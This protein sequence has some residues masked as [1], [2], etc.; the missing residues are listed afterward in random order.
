MVGLTLLLIF[1]SLLASA[2]GVIIAL[3]IQYHQ[4]EEARQER[5]GW[6]QAWEARQR[7][8]E[9]KQGKNIVD[10]EKRLSH[11]IG[12]LRADWHDWHNGWEEQ[13]DQIRLHTRVRLDMEQEIARLPHVEDVSIP[14]ATSNNARPPE[15]LAAS[16]TVPRRPARTRFLLSLH[17]SC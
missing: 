10:L 5:E 14:K 1:L 15:T 4:L 17:G 3:R 6:Q 12:E 13:L 16:S 2:L 9:V 7:A 11:Q 8:W